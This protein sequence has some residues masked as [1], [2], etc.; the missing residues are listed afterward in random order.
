MDLNK[1][2]FVVTSRL[3]YVVLIQRNI[4]EVTG[5]FVFPHK[6]S[7]SGPTFADGFKEQAGVKKAYPL[8]KITRKN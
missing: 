2:G 8:K 4:F 1:L 6:G 7:S 5:H 3:H